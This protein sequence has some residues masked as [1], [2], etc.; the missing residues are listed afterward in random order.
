[1]D[2]RRQLRVQREP[3]APL[4]AWSVFEDNYVDVDIEDHLRLLLEPAFDLAKAPL[5]RF[6]LVDG[7]AAGQTLLFGAHHGVSDLASLL[8]VAKEIDLELGAVRLDAA[9]SNH[10]IDL[11]IRAQPDRADPSPDPS[12]DLSADTAS[13]AEWRA[14]F[15]GSE[16]LELT[17]AHPR[18]DVRTFRAGSLTLDLPA[19]LTRRVAAQASRLAIT[20]AAFCLGALTVML[21][22]GRGRD[23]FALAVPVDTR[24]HAD[25]FGAVGFFGIPVPFPAEA[26]PG[27]RIDDVL[28]RTDARLNR[29][30]AKGAMFSDTLAALA[31]QG[32]YRPNAPMVEVYFNYVRA[33]GGEL[34]HSYV[35]PAGTGYS[36]LDLM[37]TMTPDAERVRLDYNLDILDEAN[38]A[39][40]G[41]DFLRVLSD[42]ADDPE[43]PARPE[44]PLPD[45]PATVATPDTDTEPA[46]TLALAATFALG[47]LPKLC[48]TALKAQP[49]NGESGSVTRT[50]TVHAT[51]STDID[52]AMRAFPAAR[53]AARVVLLRAGDLTDDVTSAITAAI[54]RAAAQRAGSLL[55]VG[56]L[57]TRDHAERDL[58]LPPDITVLRGADWTRDHPVDDIYNASPADPAD[59]RRSPYTVHFQAAVALT[60]ARTLTEPA[61]RLDPPD[62][63]AT[64]RKGLTIGGPR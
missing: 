23:R 37:I 12:P 5:W 9:P 39:A 26:M 21:A 7:G 47:V 45:A 19:E 1:D 60:L 41:R 58:V 54:T 62:T 57:P 24:I 35:L 8:I 64:S 33:D 27:E 14:Y 2:G 15:T 40:L 11:L 51:Q 48:E 16:R 20:P 10:D 56:I 44:T 34:Q 59:P 55:V 53:S 36:D 50:V 29:V 18:P 13:A 31:A 28:R 43:T 42:A 17:L 4:L 22:R 63:H 52:A 30:L 46:N 6:G 61:R 32:L 3:A 49:P 38:C 25:A